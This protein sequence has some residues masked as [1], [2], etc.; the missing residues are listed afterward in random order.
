MKIEKTKKIK[1]KKLQ[2]TK[3]KV[4]VVFS[5]LFAAIFAII[6]CVLT[7]VYFKNFQIYEKL[8]SS[9]AGG[10]GFDAYVAQHN[11]NYSSN[12][13][14]TGNTWVYA[15][16][17][18]FAVGIAFIII[19]VLLVIFS[20][21]L[22]NFLK[23]RKQLQNNNLETANQIENNQV[24]QIGLQQENVVKKKKRVLKKIK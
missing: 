19:G 23:H 20:I 3:G 11:T 12:M 18:L 15:D 14:A 4:G 9:W 6:G 8:A 21:W 24:V 13:N 5:F 10:P 1:Q 2:I 22:I 17:K 16:Y 7:A